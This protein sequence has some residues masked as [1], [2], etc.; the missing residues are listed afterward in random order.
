MFADK[1]LDAIKCLL[2]YWRGAKLGLAGRW[3]PPIIMIIMVTG[4]LKIRG[5]CVCVCVCVD[6]R[7]CAAFRLFK[8]L[9]NDS[10]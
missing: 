7:E 5:G 3:D 9:E 8:I 2:T 10:S 1:E 4:A 6:E